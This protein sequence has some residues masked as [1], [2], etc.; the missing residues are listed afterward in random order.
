MEAR[1]DDGEPRTMIRTEW[2]DAVALVTIDRPERRN[3]LD[4]DHCRLLHAA[5]DDAAARPARAVVVTGAGTAF[6]AGAD[7]GG[8]YGRDFRD[9]LYSMLGALTALPTPVIAALNGPAIGAGTQLAIAADLRVASP[10]AR[11][12]VPTAKLGL[13]VDGWTVRRL[14]LLAGGGPARALLL[15]CDEVDAA[16]ARQFGLVDRLGDLDDALAWAAEIS[17]YAPLTLAYNKLALD[18]LFEAEP[19]D[20]EVDAAFEACWASEDFAEGQAASKEKRP[21]R[22]RGR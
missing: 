20:T 17:R 5:I 7:L 18:R 11:F 10:A 2:R 8:V 19:V 21:P 3:A 1:T 22:F 6:C 14:A 16:Q 9:A 13:A 15:G 12:G 4:I